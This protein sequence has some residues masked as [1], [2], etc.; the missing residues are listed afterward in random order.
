MLKV[1]KA[2]W[3]A[4]CG[5]MM[6]H[7]YIISISLYH[8]HYTIII[9]PI[10]LYH[11]HYTNIIIPISLYHNL[12]QIIIFDDRG[13]SLVSPWYLLGGRFRDLLLAGRFLALAVLHGGRPLPLPLSPF[14][15]NEVHRRPMTA[16]DMMDMMD[17]MGITKTWNFLEH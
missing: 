1:E 2:Q 4:T 16:M 15:G 10:S 5:L 6:H 3:S 11:Y 13:I 7:Y 9:I 8:Y 12:Y 17:M 14:L